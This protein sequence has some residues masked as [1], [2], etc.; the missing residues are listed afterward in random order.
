MDNSA[1]ETSTAGHKFILFVTGMSVKSGH[2]IENLR[3]ICDKYL[4]NNYELEIVDISRDSE[5]ALVHQIVAIPTLIKTHPAPR[6]IIIGDLSD[7]EKVLKILN[8][9]E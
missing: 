9:S 2:A 5:K 7:N 8:L 3:R 6:R 1:D 4:Q